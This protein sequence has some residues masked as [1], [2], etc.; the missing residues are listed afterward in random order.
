LNT[1]EMYL[2]QGGGSGSAYMYG[3]APGPCERGS[4]SF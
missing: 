3:A 1:L 4:R 2:K